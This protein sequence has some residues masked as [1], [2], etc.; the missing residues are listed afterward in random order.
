V[1]DASAWT[2]LERPSAA[3]AQRLTP[4]DLLRLRSL[5]AGPGSLVVEPH[6]L[7]RVLV[8]LPPKC[9]M[10]DLSGVQWGETAL[11]RDRLDLE[12]VRRFREDPAA[13]TTGR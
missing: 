1:G 8:A 10:S 3:A 4:T 12:R 13:V 9:R 7:R 2:P 6:S 5:G 11:V